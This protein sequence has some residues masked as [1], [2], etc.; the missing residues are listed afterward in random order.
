L[1][2]GYLWQ[3]TSRRF[4]VVGYDER[5]GATPADTLRANG[6]DRFSLLRRLDIGASLGERAELEAMDAEV[7][8][9][10]VVGSYP[11]GRAFAI[12]RPAGATAA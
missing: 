11:D 4:P 6:L 1:I 2:Q 12:E 9:G 10:N 8:G 5:W 7:G 3:A